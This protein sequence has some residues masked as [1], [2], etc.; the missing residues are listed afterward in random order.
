MAGAIWPNSL[1]A[2]RRPLDE[3]KGLSQAAL[4]WVAGRLH[5]RPGDV[6]RLAEDECR[7]PPP[8]AF[9]HLG[10]LWPEAARKPC[11]SLSRGRA[12]CRN[13]LLLRR[14]R[15]LFPILPPRCLQKTSV[16][17]SS[18]NQHKRRIFHGAINEKLYTI[19]GGMLEILSRRPLP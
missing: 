16:S 10:V 18:S 5:A 2:V 17:N 11:G 19:G 13:T 4:A 9:F 12:S 8:A 3:M 14:G 7:P 6:F 15:R 1:F